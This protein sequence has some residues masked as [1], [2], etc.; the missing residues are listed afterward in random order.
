MRSIQRSVKGERRSER[1]SA[2]RRS[3]KNLNLVRGRLSKMSAK[4]SIIIRLVCEMIVAN[5]GHSYVTFTKV[6]FS[7]L[8]A[9]L[10]P[11][12]ACADAGDICQKTLS[13]KTKGADNVLKRRVRVA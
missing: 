6:F 7:G 8:V 3:S 9:L 5:F 11:L 13:R 10:L 12:T 2:E 1:R 4:I